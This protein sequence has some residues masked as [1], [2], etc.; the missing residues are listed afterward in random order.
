MA[1]SLAAR[2][3]APYDG[4]TDFESV[5]ERL[6]GCVKPISENSD[7]RANVDDRRGRTISLSNRSRFDHQHARRRDR[8]C[9]AH[10]TIRCVFTGRWRSNR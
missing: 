1:R 6:V 7:Q 5:E 9:H 2:F 3:D 4:T 10:S 8:S